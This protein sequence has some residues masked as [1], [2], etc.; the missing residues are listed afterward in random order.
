MERRKLKNIY[1]ET[2]FAPMPKRKNLKELIRHEINETQGIGREERKIHN[3]VK[4][5]EE[6]LEQ[7]ISLRESKLVNEIVNLYCQLH[8]HEANRFYDTFWEMFKE[9]K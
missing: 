3:K 7:T 1:G 6:E 8:Y 9:L 4:R 5:L 2:F